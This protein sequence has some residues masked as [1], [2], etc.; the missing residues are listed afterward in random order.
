MWLV[1][2]V[3]LAVDLCL[4]FGFLPSQFHLDQRSGQA[5]CIRPITQV[6]S[7]AQVVLTSATRTSR[8]QSL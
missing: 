5:W 6:T 2:A 7:D 1:I 3:L 4:S 8:T